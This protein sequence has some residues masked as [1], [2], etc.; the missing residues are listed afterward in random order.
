MEGIQN[1]MGIPIWGLSGAERTM[2]AQNLKGIYSPSII[3]FL[4]YLIKELF[5]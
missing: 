1:A 3:P 5:Y 2:C 4:C